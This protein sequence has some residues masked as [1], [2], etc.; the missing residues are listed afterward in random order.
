MSLYPNQATSKS[1]KTH[2]V[3][4]SEAIQAYDT[5]Q[6]VA[7]LLLG[8][9]AALWRDIYSLQT[10]PDDD[11]T[12]DEILNESAQILL[13]L[14]IAMNLSALLFLSVNIYYLHQCLAKDDGSGNLYRDLS[15]FT[16]WYRG[17]SVKVVFNSMPLLSFAVG[18]LLY[19]ETDG[20]ARY[21]AIGMFVLTV[22]VYYVIVTTR[23]EWSRL[24]K[25]SKKTE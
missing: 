2:L 3:D 6:V 13:I 1:K 25:L 7:A 23:N 20:L 4:Q 9:A 22:V 11:T 21:F 24:R 19:R 5:L 17:I 16:K 14:V 15:E 18:I 10:T 8:I 12:I